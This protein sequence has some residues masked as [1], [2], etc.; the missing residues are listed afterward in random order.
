MGS[1][2][3]R[4]FKA[5]AYSLYSIGKALQNESFG[6][7]C[8]VGSFLRETELCAFTEFLLGEFTPLPA[9]SISLHPKEKIKIIQQFFPSFSL[10]DVF[11]WRKNLSKEIDADDFILSFF[12]KPFIWIRVQ[13]K[14]REKVLTEL[15]QHDFIYMEDKVVKNA[16]SFEKNYDLIKLKSFESG[17][18]EIQDRSSQECSTLMHP[19]DG[20]SWWDC[21][22][23]SGGK[24][25]LLNSL[26]NNLNIFAT[27]I[28]NSM[29]EQLKVR[30]N[31]NKIRN[32][33]IA[34]WDL[35]KPIDME[36]KKKDSD[37]ILL[38]APCTGS[39]TWTASP[40]IIQTFD[41]ALI[42]INHQ[43]QI[44]IAQNVLPYLKVGKPLIY[45]TCSVFKEENEKVVEVLCKKHGLEL[46]SSKYFKGYS[47][48]AATLFGARMVKKS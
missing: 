28:R 45:I 11:P 48:R 26:A 1:T 17:Y 36:G 47:N 38:D 23:G 39:G 35:E 18:F 34:V 24:S 37:G 10:E 41:P 15:Q 22:C 43:K 27:D 20:E 33:S 30:F 4:V 13:E 12:T 32:Y 2:D 5:V 42:Q 19:A 46:E 3:R 9:E 29:F 8:S 31:R 6:V 16:I 21:C 7:R 25:L 40:E 14:F 44:A